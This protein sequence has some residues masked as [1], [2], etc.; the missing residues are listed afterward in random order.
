MGELLT[1][2]PN[3]PPLTQEKKLVAS[4]V[5][6]GLKRLV[7]IGYEPGGQVNDEISDAAMTVVF[8]LR[9]YS[10]QMGLFA[11]QYLFSLI[12]LCCQIIR[13]AMIRV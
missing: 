7:G 5:K 3:T 13:A 9:G 6:R 8:K 4:Q 10:K 2:A 11:E 1:R 12:D